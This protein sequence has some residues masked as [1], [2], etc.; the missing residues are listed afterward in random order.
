MIRSFANKETERLFGGGKSHAVPPQ[1]REKALAKL[2]SVD[3]AT[4]VRELEAPPSNRLHKLGGKREGQWSISINKQYRVCFG[5]EGGD[6]YE[7][8]IVD[9]H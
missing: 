9:Y 4:D 3:I 1:L 8:E 2:L 6:A 7:V 5:F